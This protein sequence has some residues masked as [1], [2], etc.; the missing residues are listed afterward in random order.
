MGSLE[1]DVASPAAETMIRCYD[2]ARQAWGGDGDGDGPSAIRQSRPRSQPTTTTTPITLVL[3][4]PVSTTVDKSANSPHRRPPQSRPWL[5]KKICAAPTSVRDDAP[6]RPG[7]GCAN[8]PVIGAQHRVSGHVANM[9]VQSCPM[10]SLRR[11]KMKAT[12]R[13]SSALPSRADGSVLS[14]RTLLI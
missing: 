5:R 1:E 2:G 7:S 4:P 9:A 3:R 10:P 8:A 12:C 11:A 6:A 14:T 13:V